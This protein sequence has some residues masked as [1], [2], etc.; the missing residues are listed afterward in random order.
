MG[1]KI[2]V[3]ARAD[4]ADVVAAIRAVTG[5][6]L[7]E[8]KRKLAS[9]AALV[10]GEPYDEM[11]D[12]FRGVVAALKGHGIEPAIYLLDDAESVETA[13]PEARI[14]PEVLENMLQRAEA[15]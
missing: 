13:P 11:P 14:T 5:E 12:V 7:V 2:A 9:G 4:R 6:S 10:E 1:T 3:A 8:I 15:P